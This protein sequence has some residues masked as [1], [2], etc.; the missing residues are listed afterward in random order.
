MI[1]DPG[2]PTTFWFTGIIDG[3]FTAL[4]IVFAFRGG[5]GLRELFLPEKTIDLKNK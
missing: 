4:Y 2:F 3:L 5:L 1:F